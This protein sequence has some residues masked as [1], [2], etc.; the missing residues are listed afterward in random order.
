MPEIYEPT[1]AQVDAWFDK[2]KQMADRRLK[3]YELLSNLENELPKMSE[4]AVLALSMA[5][6]GELEKRRDR[7]GNTFEK[8]QSQ[9][10]KW[11]RLT[12]I[13]LTT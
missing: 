5:V 11:L 3:Q 10:E 8:L 9:E 1:P 13:I 7:E 4:I 6:E 12:D 2:Q